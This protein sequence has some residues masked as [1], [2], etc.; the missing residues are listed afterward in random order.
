MTGFSLSGGNPQ[1]LLVNTPAGTLLVKG[2]VLE[3]VDAAANLLNPNELKGAGE[4]HKAVVL[5]G[6]GAMVSEL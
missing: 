3:G 5:V 2:D 6:Q 4:A 1:K